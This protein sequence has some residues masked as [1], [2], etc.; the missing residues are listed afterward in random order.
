[1]NRVGVILSVIMGLLLAGPVYAADDAKGKDT[2]SVIHARKSVRHFTGAAVS[3]ADLEK[4]V[5][6]G[7]AAPTA[8][9]KQPWSFILITDRK[10]LDDLAAGLL[11]ARMLSKAGAAIV[12]CT[13]VEKANGKN[14]DLAITDA[15][16]AGENILLAIEAMGLG[17]VWTA[18]NPYEDRV[19]HVKAILGI[20]ADVIPLNVIAIGVPTGE[21]QPKDKFKKERIHWERW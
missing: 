17:G 20:P 14:R 18:A 12:V 7:M 4:I 3:K 11:N 5:R 10:I 21:D 2:L 6:A 16:V 8:G 19:K 15:A 9:N 13:E 1:M